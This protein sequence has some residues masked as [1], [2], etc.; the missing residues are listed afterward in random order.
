MKL[1]V[2]K[3]IYKG[4]A[5]ELTSFKKLKGPNIKGKISALLRQI[6][7]VYVLLLGDQSRFCDQEMQ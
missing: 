2:V 4:L 6:K 7:Y 3:L 1:E 5:Y